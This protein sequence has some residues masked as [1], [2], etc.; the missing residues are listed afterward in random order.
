M[1][2][3]QSGEQEIVR[4][5]KATRQSRGQSAEQESQDLDEG[6]KGGKGGSCSVH[7][8]KR[9]STRKLDI[10]EEG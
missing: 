5:C 10:S 7:Y 1:M 9:F 8:S 4:D 3:N 6:Y 2:V